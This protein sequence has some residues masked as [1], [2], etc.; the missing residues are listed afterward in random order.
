MSDLIQAITNP[1]TLLSIVVGVLVF[2]S[3]FVG[4]AMIAAG[5]VYKLVR[6]L[7][8]PN[9]RDTRVVDAEYRV[10]R[11]QELPLPR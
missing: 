3:V 5:L 9:A 6:Q 7:G 8:K 11:K 2:F 1:Q 4:A 10:V